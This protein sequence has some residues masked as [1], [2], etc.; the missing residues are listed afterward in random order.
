MER[1]AP[2][3]PGVFWL[4]PWS[5]D[6]TVIHANFIFRF[7]S[8]SELKRRGFVKAQWIISIPNWQ[9]KR[10]M[11][12]VKICE[13]AWRGGPRVNTDRMLNLRGFT[14][15]PRTT[16]IHAMLLKFRGYGIKNS[17]AV[18]FLGTFILSS[19]IYT[20]HCALT[21]IIFMYRIHFH[22]NFIA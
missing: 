5:R 17:T 3:N 8:C 16:H 1:S 18:K 4:I 20:H 12:R 6:R 9:Q 10:P 11:K 19:Q 22:A 21:P 15:R 2:Y 7:S 14:R 13:W